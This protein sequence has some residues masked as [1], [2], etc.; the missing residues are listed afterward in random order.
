MAEYALVLTIVSIVVIVI[1]LS[2]GREIKNAFRN[3]ACDQGWSSCTTPA[4]VPSPTAC[5]T[6]SAPVLAPEVT[7]TPV[8]TF[9]PEDFS[10]HRQVLQGSIVRLLLP[11]SATYHSVSTTALTPILF[12]DGYAIFIASLPGDAQISG[13]LD[14]SDSSAAWHI[15]VS[16]VA[17]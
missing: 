2:M 9:T 16:V 1:L 3:V 5:P 10:V 11:C 13:P 14:H 7:S 6:P 12:A 15:D 17:P 8:Y 4:I